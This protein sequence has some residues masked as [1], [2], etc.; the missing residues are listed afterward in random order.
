VV[1]LGV[2]HPHGQLAV[3]VLAALV[4]ALHDDAGRDVR[5]THC[6]AGLVDVLTAGAAGL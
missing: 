1:E 2:Q 6:A 4:L 3:A 5:D